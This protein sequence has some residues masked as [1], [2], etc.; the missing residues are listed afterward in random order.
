MGRHTTMRRLLL[1]GLGVVLV[2]ACG[3]MP[4]RAEPESKVAAYFS[5]PERYP[6]P[7]W[8][9]DGRDVDSEELNSIAGP[10]HCGWESAVMLHLGWPL[11]TVSR[12]SAQIRQYIRD[13]DQV[14]RYGVSGKV[15]IGVDLPPDAQDTGYRNGALELWLAE[16]DPHAA[17]LRAGDEVER[18]PRADPVVACD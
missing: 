3:P 5:P 11:G 18:W 7:T 17:F 12:T 14:I 15:E 9:R 10:D 8:T 4:T 13:P 1:A 16:S 6:G 2:S